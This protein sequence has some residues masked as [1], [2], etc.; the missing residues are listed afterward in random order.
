MLE[1]FIQGKKIRN[2]WYPDSAF[3]V[4]HDMKS[5]SGA[6]A[7]LGKGAIATIS[8]KQKLNTKS[9]TEA[10][11]VSCDDAANPALWTKRFLEAQGYEVETIIY[12]DNTSA[13]Q[14]EKNGKE[15]SGKRTRHIDIRYFFIKDCIDKKFFTIE[16][17]P[18]EEMLGDFPS[19]PLQGKKFKKHGRAIMNSD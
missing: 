19:K 4:H 15:S 13:I 2:E 12:Q 16:Y 17:C 9:S 7:T 11:V 6:V 3:A 5:H 8:S 1:A 14:L 18:D 10:E